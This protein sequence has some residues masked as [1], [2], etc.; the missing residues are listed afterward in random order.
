MPILSKDI[1][2]KNNFRKVLSLS[3]VLVVVGFS[4]GN[5]AWSSS[6]SEDGTDPR[7]PPE[8]LVPPATTNPLAVPF[9]RP[10]SSAEKI[11]AGGQI[12]EVKPSRFR[13]NLFLPFLGYSPESRIEG[14]AGV[15]SVGHL[16]ESSKRPSSLR[17]GFL[18]SQAGHRAVRIS[19]EIFLRRD[20]LRIWAEASYTAVPDRFFGIG[21]MTTEQD[22]EDYIL[23]SN[24]LAMSVRFR[25][26]SKLEAGPWFEHR[27]SEVAPASDALQLRSGALRGSQGGNTTGLGG[28][29]TWDTRNLIF[30]PSHGRFYELVYAS[31]GSALGS[32][33]KYDRLVLDLREYMTPFPVL[34]LALQWL[35]SLTW[36]EPGFINLSSLGGPRL[37]RGYWDGRWKDLVS[38]A[39]QIEGRFPLIWRFGGVAFVSGG[40]VGRDTSEIWNNP[41][42]WAGGFGF[43]FRFDDI[44]R[45]QGRIDLAWGQDQSFGYYMFLTEAF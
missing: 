8:I 30:N 3:L 7:P 1:C 33:F 24:R 17:L 18:F 29:L 10:I 9:L 21:A 13:K 44:E 26:M 25:W 14:G 16:D 37:M 39:A 36:G 31:Y 5:P 11:L 15:L 12:G 34:T 35:G 45:I 38:S 27:T 20:R 23:R 40:Q 22:R 2:K 43:R 4:C 19:P 41:I 32:D 28:I 6:Y 42:R